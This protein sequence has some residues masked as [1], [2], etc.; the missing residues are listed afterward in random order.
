ML[1]FTVKFHC[2]TH[3]PVWDLRKANAREA[4]SIGSGFLWMVEN[5]GKLFVADLQLVR[6]VAIVGFHE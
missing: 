2:K 1:A 5:E 6:E 3:L 4:N